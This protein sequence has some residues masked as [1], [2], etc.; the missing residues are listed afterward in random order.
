MSSNALYVVSSGSTQVVNMITDPQYVGVEFPN[1]QQ[2]YGRPQ[3]I[4]DV[5]GKPTTLDL[6]TSGI[7]YVQFTCQLES[8]DVS[9]VEFVAPQIGGL[10]HFDVVQTPGAGAGS[11][12]CKMTGLIDANQATY[13]QLQFLAG[14]GGFTGPS[15][16]FIVANAFL[17]VVE[18]NA[19]TAFARYD[20]NATAQSVAASTDVVASY[21]HAVV[22]SA[23]VTQSTDGAGHKFALNRSGIWTITATDRFV[24]G[25]AGER[26]SAIWSDKFGTNAVMTADG[27]SADASVPETM[28][29][30][31]TDHFTAG[32]HVEVKVW[33]TGN[34]TLNLDAANIWKNLT[35]TLVS[36]D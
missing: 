35:M 12:N 10:I 30:S 9:D 25:T 29:I 32:D 14:A 11:I 21:S 16:Q 2:Q 4:N 7:W 8:Q 13:R 6:G 26:Y 28:N 5:N 17:S 31:Y 27:G 22:S 33:Q 36:A 23:D 24:G 18:I 19:P 20:N 1:V 15:P 34:T 3:I